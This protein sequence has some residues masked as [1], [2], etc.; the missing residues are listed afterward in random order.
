ML[1]AHLFKLAKLATI[2]VLITACSKPNKIVNVYSGRHYQTDEKLFRE[3]T[4]QTGIK[5]NLI[6]AN[7]DQLL[8]RLEMEGLHSPADLFI[9][10][11]A[12]RLI[13][14]KEKGLLQAIESDYIL[15]VVPNH[16]R[17]KEN[18]WAGFTKRA[19]VIIYS[20]ERV[21]LNELDTYESLISD[22][23]KGRLLIRS[24]QNHYNQTLMASIIAANG[25]EDATE[26]ARGITKNMSRPPAGNDRDQIKGIA[27]GIGDIAIANTYYLGLMLNS[28]NREERE[29]ASQMGVFFPNQND[30]GTHVNISGLAIAKGAPNYKHAIM[31]SEYLLSQEAQY[32]FTE[33]NYEYPVNSSVEW[34]D[35]LKEWG[36]FKTD[37]ISLFLLAG[38]LNEAMIVFNRAGWE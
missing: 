7:S 28:T 21:S 20:K 8:T 16:F 25:V 10:A 15:S 1:R 13:L 23:W 9:T 37:T 19:R 6:K 11:D 32:V 30:R 4:R 31:L 26:W 12:G 38:Y 33:E 17:D 18:Y 24:S 2:L 34:S 29:I 36:D 35:T 5:V 22:H 14:A 3:F 27:A